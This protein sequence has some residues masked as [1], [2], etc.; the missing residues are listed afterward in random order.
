MDWCKILEVNLGNNE[1]ICSE[2]FKVW[3]SNFPLK[4]E[5]MNNIL[6][7]NVAELEIRL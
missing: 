7:R 2:L 5:T 3:F 1:Y 4:E 6:N